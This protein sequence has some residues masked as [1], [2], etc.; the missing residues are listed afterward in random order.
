MMM[1]RRRMKMK[2]RGRELLFTLHPLKTSPRLATSS[3]D[4]RE[5]MLVSAG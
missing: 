5:C 3:A 4:K 1:R 2:K